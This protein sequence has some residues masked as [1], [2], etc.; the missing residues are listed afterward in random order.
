[1]GGMRKPQKSMNMKTT[2]A[3]AVC[4]IDLAA[5]NVEKTNRNS[6]IK[7]LKTNTIPKKLK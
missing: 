2:H 3:L 5:A 6:D 1:M 4:T 7:I